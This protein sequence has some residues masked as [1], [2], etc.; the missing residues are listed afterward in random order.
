MS[1]SKKLKLISLEPNIVLV[2]KIKESESSSLIKE[3]II[4]ASFLL[5]RDEA[6]E[7]ISELVGTV[8]EKFSE[9]CEKHNLNWEAELELGLQFGV[10]FSTKLKISPKKI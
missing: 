9:A 2:D 1:E 4:I 3:E 5:D 10:K 8:Y 6:I 7:S